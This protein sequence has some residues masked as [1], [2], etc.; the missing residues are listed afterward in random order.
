MSR[1]VG[2]SG[3][4]TLSTAVVTA[5]VIS[6]TGLQSS[7]MTDQ[8]KFGGYCQVAMTVMDARDAAAK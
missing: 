6:R 1:L 7:G 4:K 3:P 5:F 8:P 2:R